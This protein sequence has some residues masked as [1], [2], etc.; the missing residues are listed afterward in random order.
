MLLNIT[1][2]GILLN[3]II[4]A[5]GSVGRLRGAAEADESLHGAV[6]V[7]APLLLRHVRETLAG[8]G[9]DGGGEHGGRDGAG[10]DERGNAAGA[11]GADDE[12]GGVAR[13]GG[14]GLAEEVLAVVGIVVG[15]G[16]VGVL[17]PAASLGAV[18]HLE[19]ADGGGLVRVVV[20]GVLALPAA[21]GR[22][23]REERQLRRRHGVGGRG[24]RRRPHGE[25][26]GH[27]LAGIHG[28]RRR[29]DLLIRFA[30]ANPNPSE[31][32]TPADPSELGFRA[33]KKRI[34]GRAGSR[35]TKESQEQ[36]EED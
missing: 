34:G 8:G 9:D 11:L 2:T 30:Y 13:G 33:E 15:V 36:E 35:L 32:P 24:R 1:A 25:A 7:D 23:E 14:F 22:R 20:V 5:V 10:G 27:H 6:P 4:R 31:L 16:V 12:G 28:R 26:P 18:L 19:V 29:G 21:V 3:L 17:E